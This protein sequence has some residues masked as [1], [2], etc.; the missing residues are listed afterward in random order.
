VALVLSDISLE[1]A[2]VNWARALL[3]TS[4]CV[5]LAAIPLCFWLLRLADDVP[6]LV[7]GTII[8]VVD[9]AAFG[10]A[11]LIAQSSPVLFTPQAFLFGIAGATSLIAALLMLTQRSLKRLLVLSTIEDAGFLIFGL[12]SASTLGTSGALAAAATHAVAKALLFAC[13]SAPETAG[14]FETEPIALATRYPVSAFG[15][16]FGMLAMLGVPPTIGFMG[17]WRLYETALSIHPILLV[18]F[19]AS[20]IL[21]LIAYVLALTRAWWGPPKDVDAP[22]ITKEPLLLAGTIVA[23]AA[24]IVAGG[25]WPSALA[26]LFGGRP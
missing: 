5:K 3:L 17:R 8:A 18:I 22:P 25:I 23:L 7:L 2:Q 10:E 26:M 19:V 12:A 15:F 21:A 6:A 20:S 4:I 9:M 14:E 11:Y 1:H 16:L 24:I 13:L